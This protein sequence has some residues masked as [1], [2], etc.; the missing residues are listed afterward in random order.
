MAADKKAAHFGGFPAATKVAAEP[1][2]SPVRRRG[3][4][5][6]PKVRSAATANVVTPEGIKKTKIVTV[7]ETPDNRNYARMNVI[8][9]GALIQTELGLA[10]VTNRPGQDGVVNAVLV[11]G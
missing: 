3:G 2:Q 5:T 8:T 1:E 9:H 7:K 10:K 11:K 6:R 4:S